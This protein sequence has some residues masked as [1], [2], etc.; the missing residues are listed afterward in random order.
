MPVSQATLAR[1]WEPCTEG[2]T[3]RCG[4]DSPLCGIM[5][6]S[7]EFCRK[8]V[9][10]TADL[11]SLSSSPRSCDPSSG[12]NESAD[13]SRACVAVPDPLR[14]PS[15]TPAP[16]L[17]NTDAQSRAAASYSSAPSPLPLAPP[18]PSDDKSWPG[19]RRPDL[20]YALDAQSA[21]RLH[22]AADLGIDA[23]SPSLPLFRLRSSICGYYTA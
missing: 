21:L 4:A 9:A 6:S 10:W 20:T 8:A 22:P 18:F 15:T 23:F 16:L 5:K 2:V 11:L 19:S 3:A 7:S 14:C 13:C 1:G 12:G 17:D